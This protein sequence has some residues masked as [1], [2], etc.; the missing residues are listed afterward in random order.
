LS[1]ALLGAQWVL[2]TLIGL[3][4]LSFGLMLERL[5]FFSLHRLPGAAKLPEQ[6]LK[7]DLAAVEKALQHRTGLEASVLRVGLGARAMGPE[8]VEEL[9]AAT[10]VRERKYYERRLAFLGTLGNNAPFIGLFGTVLGIIRAF[11]E[12]SVSQPGAQAASGVGAVMS[13]I[14]EAL[15]ATAV[16]LLVAIPAVVAFN[17]FNRWLK[18][19][20]ASASELRHALIAYLRSQASQQSGR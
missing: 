18:E 3:S 5:A 2:W 17:G 8:A 13:G 11:H 4:V 15:V 14:S 10:E 12:L 16:G 19:I 6:L 7:G 1:L 20:T 9:L